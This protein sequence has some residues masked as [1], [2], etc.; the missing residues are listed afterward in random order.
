MGFLEVLKTFGPAI[1]THFL[2][3]GARGNQEKAQ[4]IQLALAK[5]MMEMSRERHD[6][7]Q[8]FREDLFSALRQRQQMQQPRFMP[9]PVTLSNPYQNVR[10]V[11]S[12]PEGQQLGPG[13]GQAL[14]LHRRNP[15]INMPLP[16]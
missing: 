3:Q 8:P 12:R 4:N 15:S 13:L 5:A 10:K 6:T 2:S 1:A 14:N 16:Q 9:G 7:E 11:S